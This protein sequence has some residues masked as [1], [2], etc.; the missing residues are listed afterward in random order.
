M[1]QISGATRTLFITP[2]FVKDNSFPN[3]NVE[4]KLLVKAIRIAEDKYI[5]PIIGGNLYATLISQ[6]RANTIAGNYK[7]LLDNFIIPCLL[8][9]TVYEYIPYT[10][11]FRNKGISKQTS[12]TSE[13]ADRDELY[14]LRDN[15]RDTAQF[16]GENL[17]KYLKV[18]SSLFPEYSTTNADQISPARGDY[19]GGI[20][21]PGANRGPGDCGLDGLGITYP[22]NL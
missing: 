4:E 21:I 15:I 6:I 14:Y 2:Q 5:Q 7:N 18:N 10:Y 9:Y 22:V 17:I 3:D 8:E 12:P 11:K 20:H 19:F 1:S 16:Y 13:P